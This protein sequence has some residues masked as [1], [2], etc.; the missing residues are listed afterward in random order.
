MAEFHLIISC[1]VDLALFFFFVCVCVGMIY[2]TFC[3]VVKVD[4]QLLISLLI[5]IH[6]FGSD[7][8]SS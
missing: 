3:S 6:V 5:F 1:Y 8:R 4:A 2:V 7:L